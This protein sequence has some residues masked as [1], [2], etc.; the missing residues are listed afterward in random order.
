MMLHLDYECLTDQ[1]FFYGL[2]S[3]KLI[4]EAEKLTARLTIYRYMSVV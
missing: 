2:I 3:K 1:G 4:C